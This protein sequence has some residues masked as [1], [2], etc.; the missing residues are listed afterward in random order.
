VLLACTRAT[1]EVLGM[2]RRSACVTR[3]TYG[4]GN[5]GA[6]PPVLTRT[7]IVAR[8]ECFTSGGRERVTGWWSSHGRWEY[9]AREYTMEKWCMD[10]YLWYASFCQGGSTAAYICTGLPECCMLSLQFVSGNVRGH[11]CIACSE[12]CC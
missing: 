2:R 9:A 4:H 10:V 6:G 7:S 3:R 5:V 1:C 12:I 8:M 11:A